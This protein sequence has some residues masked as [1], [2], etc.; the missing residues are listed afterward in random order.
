MRPHRHS[1]E[2]KFSLKSKI[3]KCMIS[4][5]THSVKSK[6]WTFLGIYTSNRHE[7]NPASDTHRYHLT[8]F[9]RKISVSYRP[10]LLSHRPIQYT[11]GRFAKES[12]SSEEKA[13]RITQH[14][15]NANINW[16]PLKQSCKESLICWYPHCYA[17]GFQLSRQHHR[18][19][20]SSLHC[21]QSDVLH[22]CGS[23][24]IIQQYR[25][26]HLRTIISLEQS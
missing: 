1:R 17:A 8:H 22:L 6:I 21:H 14:W 20:R 3:E 7:N 19:P 23:M 5:W 15:H 10:L 9:P 11:R 13:T 26:E 24:R 16:S 12:F 2:S 25:P 4:Y 18:L